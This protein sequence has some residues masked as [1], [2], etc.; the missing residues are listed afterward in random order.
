MIDLLSRTWDR[1]EHW[2][3]RL[4]EYLGDRLPEPLLLPVGLGVFV[5][6]F[7]VTALPL[8]MGLRSLLDLSPG[9]S[10][11]IWTCL[12]WAAATMFCVFQAIV[13]RS[14]KRPH[15]FYVFAVFW[16]FALW[17]VVEA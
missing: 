8:G 2:T 14:T 1:L 15:G 3:V 4:F 6:I 11:P 16:M 10:A 5:I 17:G 7:G 13:R 12:I 9:Q